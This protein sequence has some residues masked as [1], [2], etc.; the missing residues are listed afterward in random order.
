MHVAKRYT[1]P[2][3]KVSEELNRKFRPRNTILQLLIPAST[4]CPQTPYLLH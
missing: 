1:H 3:A 4:L 2:T